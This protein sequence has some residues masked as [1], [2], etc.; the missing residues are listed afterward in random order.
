MNYPFSG[1][2]ITSVIQGKPEVVPR[3]KYGGIIGDNAI[4]SPNVSVYPGVKVGTES[5]VL[6]GTILSED[7]PSFTEARTTHKVAFRRFSQSEEKK[8]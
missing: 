4:L 6:P 1:N 7:V 5:I 2:S 3:A 8:T